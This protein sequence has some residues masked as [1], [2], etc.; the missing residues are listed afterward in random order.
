M[1]REFLVETRRPGD[2]REI[3]RRRPIVPPGVLPVASVAVAFT[4][5][6]YDWCA[7]PGETNDGEEVPEALTPGTWR[8]VVA[9]VTPRWGH[10]VDA[11][12]VVVTLVGG[13]RFRLALAGKDERGEGKR[14]GGDGAEPSER[15]DACA[16]DE[17]LPDAVADARG[18]S[19]RRSSARRRGCPSRY[20]SA[21]PR[22]WGRRARSPR[23]GVHGD[24]LG[25]A[26]LAFAF[27]AGGDAIGGEGDA[28]DAAVELMRDPA[29]RSDRGK[30]SSWG[31]Y[32]PADRGAARRTSVGDG[33]DLPRRSS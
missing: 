18:K 1:R 25:A 20:T 19:S 16:V 32:L 22:C 30:P 15:F 29:R 6:T 27:R 24:A 10:P 7:T 21:V 28:A 9:T 33:W 11:S 4:D 31:M 26:E 23:G 8:R 12:A 13:V 17:R 14:G 3:R 5:P 2:A